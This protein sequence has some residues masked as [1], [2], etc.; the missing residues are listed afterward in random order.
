VLG[1]ARQRGL[2]VL[3]IEQRLQLTQVLADRALVMGGGRIV[4]DLAP[5]EILTSEVC[6]QWLM[7]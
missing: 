3:L 7:V 6:N 2:A 1:L 4:V 5:D